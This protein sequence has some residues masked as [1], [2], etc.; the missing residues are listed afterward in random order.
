MIFHV[1]FTMVH[2]Q[3]TYTWKE[4]THPS[5]H[6]IFFGASKKWW[7]FGGWI[8]MGTGNL[9]PFTWGPVSSAR[10][11]NTN[12]TGPVMVRPRHPETNK[13]NGGNGRGRRDMVSEFVSWVRN[14]YWRLY[15]F[16]KIRKRDRSESRIFLHGLTFSWN[17]VLFFFKYLLLLGS[18]GLCKPFGL[19][20]F[21]TLLTRRRCWQWWRIWIQKPW[22][23]ADSCM[24]WAWPQKIR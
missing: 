19:R 23:G 4:K 6:L 21:L 24:T 15:K 3:I 18:N 1:W 16:D 7:I 9:L 2:L 11:K 20:W 14:E 17:E 10:W 22:K 12:G 8:P 5:I 13:K